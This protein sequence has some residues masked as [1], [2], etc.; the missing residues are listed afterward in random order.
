M[1]WPPLAHNVRILLP[2][3][4]TTAFDRLALGLCTVRWHPNACALTKGHTGV[5]RAADG[6]ALV[7]THGSGD[8]EPTSQPGG[9]ITAER[10]PGLTPG[11]GTG[12]PVVVDGNQY[13]LGEYDSQTDQYALNRAREVH[14]VTAWR[15][16]GRIEVVH[17]CPV[18]DSG[19]TP[20]CNLT[21]FELPRYHRL[22]EDP[23]LVTCCP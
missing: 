22:T 11:D 12:Q 10:V 2:D 3:D 7:A 8:L 18:G 6:S 20:C 9:R 15:P 13:V 1:S 19:V 17:R 5:H 14:G 23:A 16:E 21:P 4:G